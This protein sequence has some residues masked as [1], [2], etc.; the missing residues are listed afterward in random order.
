MRTH[1]CETKKNPNNPAAGISGCVCVNH[2]WPV[3]AGGGGMTVRIITDS[4][5][6]K[7]IT[8]EPLLHQP[9]PVMTDEKGRPVSFWGGKS[10]EPIAQ[11][12][13]VQE[14]VWIQPDH[15]QKAQKAPFLCRVEPHKRDDFVPLYTTPPAQPAVPLTERDLASACLSYRHDF[16]LMDETNRGLLMFQAREWARALGLSTAAAPEKGGAA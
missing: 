16:G 12:A 11:P 5:G 3:V 9:A 1:R 6:R 8:N 7:H 13:P 4:N 10:V 2:L 15:L 14:P